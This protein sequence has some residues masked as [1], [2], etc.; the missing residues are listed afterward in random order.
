M[1]K[2]YNDTSYQ[3]SSLFS[4]K[5]WKRP[6][7]N[8]LSKG[9]RVV[10]WIIVGIVLL[11]AAAMCGVSLYFTPKR[12]A[13]IIEKESGKYLDA[14]VK[15][16]GIS[17]SL[18][19]SFPWLY[20]EVDS[21]Y[22]ISKSLD[23]ISENQKNLI[24]EDAARLAFVGKIKAALDVKELMEGDLELKDVEVDNIRANIVIVDDK[25]ANYNILPDH[26]K[27][28]KTPDV[29]IKDFKI[30]AP[31]NISFFYLPDTIAA[32][33][34]IASFFIDTKKKG[35]RLNLGLEGDMTGRYQNLS[36]NEPIDFKLAIEGGYGDE[37]VTLDLDQ[38]ALDLN[39]IKLNASG[40][41]TQSKKEVR[42]NDFECHL[43]IPDLFALKEHLPQDLQDKI[44]IP[45][46]IGGNIPLLVDLKLTEGFNIPQNPAGLLEVLPPVEARVNISGGNLSYHPPHEK[47]IVADDIF[48]ECEALY[49]SRNPDETY[50]F[51]KQL[52][53]DGEGLYVDCRA[54]VEEMLTETPKVSL[55]AKFNS[56]VMK[57]VSYLLPKSGMNLDGHLGGEITFSGVPLDFGR[58]GVKDISFA[59]TFESKSLKMKG[60]KGNPDLAVDDMDAEISA[61]LPFYPSSTYSGAD[62][63]LD[64]KTG[65]MTMKSS[66][67]DNFIINGLVAKL[68]VDKEEGQ[69]AEPVASLDFSAGSLFFAQSG[70]QTL[71]TQGIDI[72]MKGKLLSSPKATPASFSLPVVAEDSIISNRSSHTP[73]YLNAGGSGGILSTFMPMADADI[74]LSV[75]EGE[76]KTG[77]YLLPINFQDLSLTTDLNTVKVNQGKAKIGNSE[78]SIGGKFSGLYG[79]LTSYEPV[80]LKADFD[81]DFDNVD[82]DELSGGYYGA[83]E[84]IKGD[85]AF[86]IPPVKPYTASDSVC[87]AIPRNIDANIRLHALSAEYM[88]YRFSPLST[89]I[90]VNK[91]DATLSRLTIGS[92][93][94][95]VVVDW[96]YSTSSF[97]N[98]FMNL[99][100]DVDNFS[101]Q[102]FFKVFPQITD[103][104]PYIKDISGNISASVDARFLMYPSMFMDFPSSKARFNLKGNDL[105]FS[106]H[107]KVEKFTH[108]MRIEG[109]APIR[110]ENLD[111]TGTFHDNLL[112]LN[113]FKIRFDDYQIG[114]AG[115]N[116]MQGEMYYHVALEKSPFH[117]PFGVNLVGNF[118]HPEVRLG[119]TGIN[120]DRERKIS[121]D[122]E[123]KVD[124]NIM[125]YLKNGWQM[126]IQEAAKYYLKVKNEK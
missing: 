109:D 39:F 126:F 118:S 100:A 29:E 30:N 90:I 14:E 51:V 40:N 35:N 60:G 13:E 15:V 101:F 12:L 19:H 28:M 61:S 123:D 16:K 107:G 3:G 108:L 94:A 57:T 79:L 59:G 70:N 121:E 45:G 116:N 95:T 11:L 89:T 66:P 49:A 2:Y 74:E 73:L 55:N 43:A 68:Q 93:Y 4:R 103:K 46:N 82:I 33:I 17:Y 54:R 119:G 77:S 37:P 36:L 8:P 114:V 85:S 80:L 41:V 96:T 31:L 104:S 21:L 92:T 98:I 6:P 113:P 23:G 38:L 87:I 99:H 7:K 34:D 75:K 32:N 26:L 20:L 63:M 120:D 22:V 25:V 47:K 106:R 111:I 69:N 115:V 10:A 53:M 44:E 102:P 117:L 78:M 56:R 24:P 91:G 48:L 52:R 81:I 1:T 124:V 18:I 62:I 112:E 125:A 97:N 76:F 71:Q 110:L 83:L 86:Y 105:R 67:Q 65:K 72:D 84:K 64:F 27:K 9:V 5:P 122:L 58:K 88:G 42:V 50:L